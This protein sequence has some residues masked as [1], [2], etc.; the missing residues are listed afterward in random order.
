MNQQAIGSFIAKKRREK[1]ITQARLAEQLS[2]SDKTVS[3]W[4]TGKCMPDYSI[5]EPLC[6]ALDITIAELM[7]GEE[8]GECSIPAYDSTQILE[9]VKRIQA[10]EHQRT[11]LYGMILIVTGIMLLV[12]Y[13]NIYGSNVKNFVSGLLLGISIAEM[14]VGVY[15]TIRGLSSR[16]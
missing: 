14:L 7:D 13:C 5:I 12:L 10:L 1:N 15:F 11:M 2:V 9:L 4:E 16:K 3:K 6:K 8:S